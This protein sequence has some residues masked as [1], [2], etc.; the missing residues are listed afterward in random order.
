MAATEARPEFRTGDFLSF[1][2][3]MRTTIAEIEIGV[4]NGL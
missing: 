1:F 4:E 2:M 3:A